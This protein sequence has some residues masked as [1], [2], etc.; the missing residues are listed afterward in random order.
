MGWDRI[1]AKG[2]TIARIERSRVSSGGLRM[3]GGE[4][5]EEEDG[6]VELVA[7][8]GVGVVVVQVGRRNA[9]VDEV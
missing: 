4:V 8:P 1:G 2:Q 9:T 7:V 6:E 5:V 3:G